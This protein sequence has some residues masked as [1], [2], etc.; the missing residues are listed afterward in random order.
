MREKRKFCKEDCTE[1]KL[2][3]MEIPGQAGNDMQGY[4]ARGHL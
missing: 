1:V 4:Q 2:Y 3:E